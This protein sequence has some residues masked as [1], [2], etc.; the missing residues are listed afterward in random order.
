MKGCSRQLSKDVCD[1]TWAGART[2]RHTQVE[3]HFRGRAIL[4]DAKGL[5][6]LT[7]RKLMRNQRLRVDSTFTQQLDAAVP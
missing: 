3:N 4:G 7:E 2:S 5:L 1:S 6:K